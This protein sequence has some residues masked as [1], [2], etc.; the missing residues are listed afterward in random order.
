MPIVF[1]IR[2]GSRCR[3]AKLTEADIPKIRARYAAGVSTTDIGK[4]FGISG[5][6]A[7]EIATR[8]AWT[9]VE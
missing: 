5:P 1:E 3:N 6:R 2:K 9:H 7:Y 4:E 8:R